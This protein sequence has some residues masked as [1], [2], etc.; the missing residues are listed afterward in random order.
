MNKKNK[1]KWATLFLYGLSP[2]IALSAK[3]KPKN[4]LFI[5]VDDYGWNNRL[6]RYI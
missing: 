4:V 6:I 1:T 2:W 5:L 3:E